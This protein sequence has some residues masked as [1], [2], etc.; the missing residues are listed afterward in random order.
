[1]QNIKTKSCSLPGYG[2]VEN[3]LYVP[4][5]QLGHTA[6]IIW[7]PVK[8]DP[9]CSSRPF[10][11]MYHTIHNHNWGLLWIL[12]N[13]STTNPVPRMLRTTEAFTGKTELQ[14]SGIFLLQTQY[15]IPH[16]FLHQSFTLFHI[17][18]SKW[19]NAILLVYTYILGV[20]ATY[21]KFERATK[22]TLGHTVV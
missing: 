15:L 18:L 16:S 7:R 6:S 4:K 9:E 19:G 11:T 13:L 12:T 3:D 20:R 14:K 8:T 2:T 1:V 21:D 17:C 5:F 22:M 10:T